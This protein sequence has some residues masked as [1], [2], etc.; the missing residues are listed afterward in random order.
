MKRFLILTL[1]LIVAPNSAT[2]AEMSQTGF[3]GKVAI[4][5]PS[6]LKDITDC[7]DT[8]CGP[9]LD[10]LLNK[11]KNIRS[12]TS[13]PELWLL[14]KVKALPDPVPGYRIGSDRDK[15]IAL[16]EGKKVKVMAFALVARKGS[17]E[18]CNCALFAAA[19]TDNMIVLVEPSG[20]PTLMNDEAKG[21]S[22]EI[23][24]RVRLDHPG[25]T[26]AKL[27]PLI[28]SA[29]NQTLL[30]RVTGL[31]LFDSEHSFGRGLRRKTN[32]E[33]HPVFRLEYCPNGRKCLATSDANWID[34]DK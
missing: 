24:P 21:V 10:P 29:P 17:R 20:R 15:L 30:V 14:S 23:T 31:L 16:G 27:Q 26:Q 6:K 7:P 28:I 13:D 25:L 34:L 12:D 1:L 9:A 33:I 5:C 32:W 8:G 11:Q 2:D 19:D 3:S 4:K 22:A 18:S